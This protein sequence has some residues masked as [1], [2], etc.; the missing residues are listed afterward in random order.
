MSLTRT[1]VDASTALAPPLASAVPSPPGVMLSMDTSSG[2]TAV[3]VTPPSSWGQRT[4]H[5]QQHHTVND[6][7]PSAHFHSAATLRHRSPRSHEL[8]HARVGLFTHAY[9]PVYAVALLG[10]PWCKDKQPDMRGG[11]CVRQQALV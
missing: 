2:A 9:T 11:R 1:G 10:R 7:S 5:P 6:I 4:K 8:L 3:E